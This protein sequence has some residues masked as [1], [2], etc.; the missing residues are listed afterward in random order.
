MEA[1]LLGN[2]RYCYLRYVVCHWL[3]SSGVIDRKKNNLVQSYHF[4]CHDSIPDGPGLETGEG[5]AEVD[6]HN[7]F[8]IYNETTAKPEHIIKMLIL[9]V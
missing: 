8:N 2:D 4:T 3:K 5:N 9:L 7:M 1:K 6:C